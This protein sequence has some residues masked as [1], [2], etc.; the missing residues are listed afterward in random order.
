MFLIQHQLQTSA[1]PD[2]TAFW[3]SLNSGISA[4]DEIQLSNWNPRAQVFWE[5]N[6]GPAP[7]A[8]QFSDSSSSHLLAFKKTIESF[9]PPKMDGRWGILFSSTKGITEDY[10][11]DE[12]SWN[13]YSPVLEL[14]KK[15]LD[16][17]LYESS[18]VSNA[19]ASAHAALHL[20]RNWIEQDRVDHVWLVSGDLIGPFTMLGFKSL[21]ALCS[22]S[23]QS[24]QSKRDGLSLGESIVSLVLSKDP[25]PLR[26]L[27]TGISNDGLSTTRPSKDCLIKTMPN[28]KNQNI[29]FV[30]GHGTGT[31]A[32]DLAEIEALN[33][34]FDNRI[35]F[36]TSTKWCVGH[37][38]GASGA[39]DVV[40]AAE[41]MNTE[42][43]FQ[44]PIHSDPISGAESITQNPAHYQKA[45]ITSLGFGGTH[46]SLI[47]ERV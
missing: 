20:A 16:G 7:I 21:R 45:L 30:I 27:H 3:N 8:A 41:M 6:W 44:I 17:D 24:Y 31:P 11:W 5:K 28:V 35:P 10:V 37:T 29:G 22:K 2:V 18:T 32:N 19:C 1:G 9:T 13:S 38:L 25:S 26:F 15:Q 12:E 40:A 43:F 47:L 23:V 4:I 34:V 46:A 33:D 42:K 14:L 36:L 39:V